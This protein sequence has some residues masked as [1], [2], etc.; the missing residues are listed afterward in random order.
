[1]QLLYHNRKYMLD[2][3]LFTVILHYVCQYTLPS[4]REMSTQVNK[5]GLKE[6][7]ASSVQVCLAPLRLWNEDVI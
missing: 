6:T 1:M 7:I 3:S 5:N 4:R 2:P